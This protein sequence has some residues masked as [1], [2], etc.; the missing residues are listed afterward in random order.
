MDNTA[1][2]ALKALSPLDGR[3]QNKL[4]SLADCFCEQAL[5][6]QRVWVECEWLL[7]LNKAGLGPVPLT[8]D[9]TE[10]ITQTRDRF[11][12]ADALAI[13]SIERKTQHDVKAVEQ[14]LA[15]R[16]QAHATLRPWIAWIHFAC[17]SE[18]INNLAYGRLIKQALSTV[19][20]PQINNLINALRS[21][22]EQSLDS[23]MLGRTHGQPA[24]PTTLGK[25]MANLLIRLNNAKSALT[26]CPIVGKCNG[27]VGNFN[28]HYAAMPDVDWPTLSDRM[29]THC[30]LVPNRYTTQIE[31]HDYI[32]T[33][34]HALS[35]LNTILID[36]ARDLWG[37]ISLGY[38]TQTSIKTEVGSSTMPHKINPIHFENA[39]GNLGLCNA[40]AHHLASSLPLSRFQRDLTDSTTMRNIGLCLGYASLAYQ[41]FQTGLSKCQAN[42]NVMEQALTAHPEI[43]AEAVQTVMRAEGD[44][45]AYDKLKAFTR[46]QAITAESLITFIQHLDIPPKCKKDLLTLTPDRYIGIAKILAQQALEQTKS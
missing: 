43:L 29:I 9:A 10:I 36:G 39:E 8:A 23:V 37:Y 40:L 30:G 34:L 46:G 26:Q 4:R 22:S 6:Q 2:H 11:S 38:L 21:F 1:I 13:K 24:S 16:W 25:E 35:R 14:W 15:E 45:N 20:E 12:D 19:I 33:L 44:A 27:A 41:A 7:T 18:D 32:A 3:Y 5:I 17:T 31:P 42:N 28:A